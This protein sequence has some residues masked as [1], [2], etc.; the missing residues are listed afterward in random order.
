[1]DTVM[2]DKYLETISDL[3]KFLSGSK[4]LILRFKTIEDKYLFVDEIIDR[5]SYPLLKRK[6][7]RVVVSYLKKLTG[8]KHSQLFR[9]IDRAA[10]G[11]LIRKS[12]FR[13]PDYHRK[14]SI[15]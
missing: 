1:M 6:E 10:G 2:D 15:T 13:K 4:R 9:L 7:K 8:Y 12:Y 14:Y 5:F 3:E 11:E